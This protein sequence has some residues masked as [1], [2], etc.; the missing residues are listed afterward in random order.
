M[1]GLFAILIGLLPCLPSPDTTA[2]QQTVTRF[3]E[4]LAQGDS[5]TVAQLLLDEVVILEG[6]RRES[7]TEY[8]GHHYSRDVAFL[9]AMQ[10]SIIWQQVRVFDELAYVSTLSRLR[11][12]FRERSYDLASAELL[13]LHRTPDGWR[14]GAIHWS[15]APYR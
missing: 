10:R 5:A 9:Q 14:I 4:A 7:K 3:H 13:V 11:G 15:S 8:L 1:F 12:T 2:V 6:G